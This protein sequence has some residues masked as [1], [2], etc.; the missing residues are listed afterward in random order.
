MSYASPINPISLV[1][2]GRWILVLPPRRD[3]QPTRIEN[4]MNGEKRLV[5]PD[6]LLTILGFDFLQLI[7][8]EGGKRIYGT[9]KAKE[10]WG[11]IE[12]A[13]R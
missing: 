10:A 1:L 6:D 3:V 8:G 4:L 9:W 11:V 7:H 13:I 12:S 5:N 2:S